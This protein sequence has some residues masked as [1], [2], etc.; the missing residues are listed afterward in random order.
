MLPLDTR[1]Y[2]S[3]DS[4]QLTPTLVSADLPIEI[5]VTRT[6]QHSSIYYNVA[7]LAIRVGF[8]VRQVV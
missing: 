3:F 2:H 4:Q 7:D 5:N 6:A 1:L 8:R